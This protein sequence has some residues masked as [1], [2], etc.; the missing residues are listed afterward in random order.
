MICCK[1][2]SRLSYCP[3]YSNPR[4]RKLTFYCDKCKAFRFVFE[5]PS[6]NILTILLDSVDLKDILPEGFEKQSVDESAN[7]ISPSVTN[8]VILKEPPF[9]DGEDH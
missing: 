3:Q 2:R 5:F 1:C 4:A 7:L 9:R 8:E 6:K